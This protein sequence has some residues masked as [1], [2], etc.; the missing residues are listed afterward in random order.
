[1][2]PPVTMPDKPP[3]PWLT[4]VARRIPSTIPHTVSTGW[5]TANTDGF[6]WL[7]D[8]SVDCIL[9]DPP[10]NIS[11]ETNFET[12]AGNTVNSYQ[13]DRGTGWDSHTANDFRQLIDRW[14]VNFARVLKPDGTFLVFMSDR[15]AGDVVQ[16]LE[17]AGLSPQGIFTWRKPN[18]VPVNRRF[19]MTSA[20]ELAIVGTANGQPAFTIPDRHLDPRG[21][22]DA[23]AAITADYAASQTREAVNRAIDTVSETG[24]ERPAAIV[25]AAV[26]AVSHLAP[27]VDLEGA[28]SPDGQ[29]ILGPP[30]SI[31][32]DIPRGAEKRAGGGH[33]TQKPIALLRYLLALLSS[34]GATVLDPFAGSGSVGVAAIELQRV[35]ILVEMNPDYYATATERLRLATSH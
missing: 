30:M 16:G 24:D 4:E 29:L 1:M 7:P 25:A 10:Y 9:T 26:Q 23:L 34:P 19:M 5:L 13:F 35:P 31:T 8:N 3:A 20:T 14:A 11:R 15:H 27:S 22:Q 21:H 12:F 28:L 33:P 2:G 6:P 18:P 32:V 17:A